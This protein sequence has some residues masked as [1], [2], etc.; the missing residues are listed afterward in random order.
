M[1]GLI[2]PEAMERLQEGF[3][4]WTNHVN[5]H[6]CLPCSLVRA[7]LKLNRLATNMLGQLGLRL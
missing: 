5:T 2:C 6:D 4:W 1:T 3:T 7:A